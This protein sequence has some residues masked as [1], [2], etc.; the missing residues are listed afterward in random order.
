MIVRLH[1]HAAQRLLERGATE[2]EVV[3][4]VQNGERFPANSDEPDSAETFH[5]P[6]SGEGHIRQLSNWSEEDGCWLVI[7]VLVRYY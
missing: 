1:P 2:A 3:A 4:T 5:S 6:D 7:T